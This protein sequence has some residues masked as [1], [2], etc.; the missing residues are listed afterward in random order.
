[1]RKFHLTIGLL[2]LLGLL[3]GCYSGSRGFRSDA[4]ASRL[5]AMAAE[6]AGQVDRPRDRLSRQL[7]IANMQ[8]EQGYSAGARRTLAEAAATLGKDWDSLDVQTRLAG[9]VSIS[10]LSRDSYDNASA[11]A[12][13]EQAV[14]V[15]RGIQPEA[16]RCQYV[17][18]VAGELR[19]LYGKAR[20]AGLLRESG[21]WAAKIEAPSQRRAIYTGLASDL[22]LCD[23]YDGGRDMIRRDSDPAWRS[24]TLAELARQATPADQWSKSLQFKSNFYQSIGSHNPS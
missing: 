2:G 9:W 10:E 20:S 16:D 15:L 4:R 24:D 23:D 12:A 7:N 18:G 3:G 14:A 21:T 8:N 5:M 11:A 1:M 17:R 19:N 6:E 22:F 13:C